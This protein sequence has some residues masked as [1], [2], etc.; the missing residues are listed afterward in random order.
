MDRQ[1]QIYRAHCEKVNVSILHDNKCYAEGLLPIVSKGKQR[2]IGRANF[3]VE[4][5]IEVPCHR[6]STEVEVRHQIKDHLAMAYCVE[7]IVLSMVH[8]IKLDISHIF[9]PKSIESLLLIQESFTYGYDKD[10]LLIKVMK[11][12]KKYSPFAIVLYTVIYHTHSIIL[13]FV[14]C[15]KRLPFMTSLTFLFRCFKTHRDLGKYIDAQKVKDKTKEKESVRKSMHYET[16]DAE[17]QAQHI[18]AL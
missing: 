11:L 5:A 3:L 1:G 4:N 12:Y 15:A 2:F 13:F 6:K 9:N 16:S 17:F 7:N 8:K 14:A 18:A 10:H